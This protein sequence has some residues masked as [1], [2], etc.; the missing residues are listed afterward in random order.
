MGTYGFLRFNIQLFPD[1]T[2]Q[3]A[4]WIALLATIGIIYGAAVS[5]A[6]QM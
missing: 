3:A 4:P 5:Y 2:V 6:Q 1:A